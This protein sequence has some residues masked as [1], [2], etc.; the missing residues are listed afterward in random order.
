M[1][2]FTDV[3]YRQKFPPCLAPTGVHVMDA[4]DTELSGLG[5]LGSVPQ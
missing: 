1:D 2:P 5:S 3:Y 4:F